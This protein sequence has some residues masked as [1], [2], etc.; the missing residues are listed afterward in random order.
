MSPD[1][2]LAT[3][4][5][6]HANHLLKQNI[7]YFLFFAG[8]LLKIISHIFFHRYISN[9][10]LRNETARAVFFYKRSKSLKVVF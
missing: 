5:L 2:N 10:E 8:T 7:A 4:W 9:I 1:K 6:F 3:I